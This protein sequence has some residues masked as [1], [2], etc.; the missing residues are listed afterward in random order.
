MPQCIN[1]ATNESPG[2]LILA[3][4]T[5]PRD[6]AVG[7]GLGPVT[8]TTIIHN[9]LIRHMP[10]CDLGAGQFQ[11]GRQRTIKIARTPRR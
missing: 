7:S 6:P 10:H 1:R 9:R 5:D 11:R 3:G 8:V 2:K 4:I